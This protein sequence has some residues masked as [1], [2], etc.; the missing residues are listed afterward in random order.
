VS[1]LNAL[2]SGLPRRRCILGSL[3]LAS[4][5]APP[6]WGQRTSHEQPEGGGGSVTTWSLSII[7]PRPYITLLP[8]LGTRRL[9]RPYK[10]SSP[11]W[12]ILGAEQYGA[13]Y[14]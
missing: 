13:R 12:W 2:L 9:A 5:I 10:P 7:T 14:L 8:S 1:L 11:R 6:A 3:Q 4:C